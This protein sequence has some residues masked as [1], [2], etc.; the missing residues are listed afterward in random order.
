MHL[1][2]A[3][4]AVERYLCNARCE[5]RD[6]CVAC[7][8][9]CCSRELGCILPWKILALEDESQRAVAGPKHFIRRRELA[10]T[11][12]DQHLDSSQQHT[13]PYKLLPQ[14]GQAAKPAGCLS[15]RAAVNTLTQLL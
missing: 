5:F 11:D 3:G 15:A 1:E 10:L 9:A 14:I 2:M 13:L 7:C 12:A 8:E 4:T 6:S